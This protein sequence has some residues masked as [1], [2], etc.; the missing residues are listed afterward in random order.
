MLNPVP[1]SEP[2][3]PPRVRPAD[4]PLRFPFYVPKLLNN[5]LELVPV[6][7]YHESIVIGGGP[8]RM[9][10]ITGPEAVK[11]LFLDRAA[12][13]PKGRVQNGI[14]RPLFGKAMIT[15]EGRDWRWQ[16]GAAAPL[17][18]HDEILRYGDVM[19]AAAEAAVAEW[20]AAGPDIVHPIHTQMMRAAFAVISKTMLAGGAD[21]VLHAIA[22]GHADYYRGVNWWAVYTI[23]GLPRW[24]PRP[25]GRAM[26]AH[27]SRLR[28]AVRDLVQARH[29]RM[30]RDDLI[31]KLLSNPDPETGQGM[32]DELLVDNIVAFL[33]AGYDTTALAL[34]WTLYL[35]SQSPRWETRMLE[36]IMRVVGE[37]PVTAAHAA[38][39][40][41]VQQVLNESLRLYPTAPIIIRDIPDETEIDGKVIPG[42]TIG[43]VPIYAIHRHHGFW[44]DPDRF[45]PGRFAP[46]S[47][48]KPSRYQFMPFGVGP[49]I[50]IGAAF[51][52]IEA[53][54]MLATFVRA[55]RFAYA[56]EVPPQPSGQMFLLPRNGMFM[57]VTPREPTT[58]R[59]SAA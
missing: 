37:G 22:Q 51:A 45:D 11:A 19:T 18:R 59:R 12:E 58:E 24:L 9:A 33:M 52:T 30:E 16:R 7:A 40:V 34:T 55:A 53:T 43:I 23:F 26:R 35:V 31:T 17:F 2:F 29:D 28:D 8:P 32:T 47:P 6:Q 36:E 1:A 39:L 57:R 5:N 25:R 42:G 50:C 15:A 27:E 38:K 48:V 20:R 13:F 14:F 41:T 56:G 44:R 49:R 21:D 4:K 54:I 46:D 3:Y 10:W